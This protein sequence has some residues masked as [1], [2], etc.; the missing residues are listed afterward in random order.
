[1][2]LSSQLANYLHIV[3][4]LQL[5]KYLYI[6]VALTAVSFQYILL[7]HELYMFN[8]VHETDNRIRTEALIHL[9]S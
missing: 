3:E 1:M 8:L 4:T 7:P 6:A 9:L 5:Q 2:Y